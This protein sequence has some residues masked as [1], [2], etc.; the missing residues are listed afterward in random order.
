[1]IQGAPVEKAMLYQKHKKLSQ[2]MQK[3]ASGR[4]FQENQRQESS[5]RSG[6][7]WTLTS[8]GRGR[9]D[10]KLVEAGLGGFADPSTA[11]GV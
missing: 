7:F 6:Y 9:S 10:S 1:M 4:Y 2:A 11:G 3:N 5:R 8:L